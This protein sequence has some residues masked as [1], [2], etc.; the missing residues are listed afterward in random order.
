[1]AL[2]LDNILNLL[3]K[4]RENKEKDHKISKTSD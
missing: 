4:S 3:T 2:I 1:M